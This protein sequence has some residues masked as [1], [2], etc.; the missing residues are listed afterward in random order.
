MRNSRFL[1]VVMGVS[2]VF[3]GGCIRPHEVYYPDPEGK[4]SVVGDKIYLNNKLYAELRYEGSYYSELLNDNL[5]KDSPTGLAIYYFPYDE[6]EWIFP[7]CGWG[8]YVLEEKK[9]YSTIAEMDELD[10]TAKEHGYTLHSNITG[11]DHLDTRKVYLMIGNNKFELAEKSPTP[12]A[13]DICITED[14]KYVCYKSSGR[15]K[16]QSY[17]VKYGECFERDSG[18]PRRL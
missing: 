9:L 11:L 12:I 15:N 14:G 13:N 1:Q 2:L 3:L 16:Q 7:K 18:A 4:V 5:Y 8:Y 10:R 17:R 6:Q